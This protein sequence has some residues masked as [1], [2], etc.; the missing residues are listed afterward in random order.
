MLVVAN[1]WG[2]TNAFATLNSRS[3]RVAG[4]PAVFLIDRT[5]CRLARLR[6]IQ[7]LAATVTL[8]ATRV[9]YRNG[10]RAV[11]DA[12]IENN[13]RITFSGDI[14]ENPHARLILPRGLR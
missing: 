9:P 12:K 8:I 10:R 3:E 6:W 2:N 13:L 11:E 14:D 5:C 1:L 7:R 4:Q